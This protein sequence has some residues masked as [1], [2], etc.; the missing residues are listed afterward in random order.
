MTTLKYVRENQELTDDGYR[1]S[2]DIAR[3]VDEAAEA[4]YATEEGEPLQDAVDQLNDLAHGRAPDSLYGDL[5]NEDCGTVR[6][7]VLSLFAPKSCLARWQRDE[8]VEALV[9]RLTKRQLVDALL[10]YGEAANEVFRL[11][12][13]VAERGGWRKQVEG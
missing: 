6:E 4:D 1:L 11:K 9:G 5:S 2:E 12:W 3:F 8:L 10:R 13:I 7:I